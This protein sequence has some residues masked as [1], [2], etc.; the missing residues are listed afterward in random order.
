MQLGSREVD[1]TACI[2]QQVTRLA[3]DVKP[4]HSVDA[5]QVNTET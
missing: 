4:G 2:S 3:A 5:L 1:R